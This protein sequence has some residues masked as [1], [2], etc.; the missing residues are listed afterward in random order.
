MSYYRPVGLLPREHWALRWIGAPAVPAL[1]DALRH[2][3]DEN[4][5]SGAADVLGRLLI[6][7][8]CAKRSMSR[9]MIPMTMCVAWRCG[10]LGD[11]AI[12]ACFDLLLAEQPIQGRIGNLPDTLAHIGSAAVP[13]LI[14]ALEDQARPAYQRVNAAHALGLI[15]DERTVEP[16]IAALRDDDEDVR[17]AAIFAL[18]DLK[19]HQGRWNHCWPRCMTPH[20]RC[21]DELSV[22]WRPLT[23]TERLT[24]LRV[25]YE[26]AGKA[27]KAINPRLAFCGLWRGIMASVRSRCSARWRL[28]MSRW[29]WL[30]AITRSGQLGAPAVPVLLEIGRDPRP[31]RRDTAITW[32]KMA[33]RHSPDPR[34]VDF[35]FEVIQE[36]P[37]V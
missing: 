20:L 32:L 29:R 35:L 23:T 33:Y 25:L 22:S 9:W 8:K 7:R 28:V 34:I 1:L 17:V 31:E 19:D 16:L 30:L 12:R 18:G 21:V 13:P 11:L 4:I 14:A 10:R 6:A 3:E 26:R 36:N 2:A 24:R 5:R 15:E 27:R 37:T